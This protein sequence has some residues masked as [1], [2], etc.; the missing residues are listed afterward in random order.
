M[1]LGGLVALGACREP[2]SWSVRWRVAPRPDMV[3]DPTTTDDEDVLLNGVEC[4]RV[5]VSVVDLISIAAEFDDPFIVDRRLKP[6]WAPAMEDP[7]RTLGGP[8]LEPGRYELI[9]RGLRASREPWTYCFVEGDAEVCPDPF[10]APRCE[11][12]ENGSPVCQRGYGSCDCR[13][14]DVAEGETLQIRDFV[15]DA[16]PECEDG[17]DGE[18]R[19]PRVA[20]VWT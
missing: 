11:E 2:P 3:V 17:I 1:L 4:S 15:I 6:C 18:G 13:F 7:N 8:A 16:P 14:I 9:A 12:D 20:M 10:T 5:G 19:R